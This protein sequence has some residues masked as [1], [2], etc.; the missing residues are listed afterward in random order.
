M[1]AC[2]FISERCE[3]RDITLVLITCAISFLQKTGQRLAATGGVAFLADIRNH[4]IHRLPSRLC[5][6]SQGRGIARRPESRGG[7]QVESGD[8]LPLGLLGTAR[9]RSE[10]HVAWDPGSRRLATAAQ[11]PADRVLPANFVWSFI[12]AVSCLSESPCTP[13][14]Y[15]DPNCLHSPPYANCNGR[16]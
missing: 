9:G 11:V 4:R 7:G 14:G 15:A 10:T 5:V 16:S 13:S 6:E 8:Q 12:G 3:F 2:E 1:L